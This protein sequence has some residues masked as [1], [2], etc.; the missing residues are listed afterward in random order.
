MPDTKILIVDDEEYILELVKFNLEK[1]GFKV[2]TAYDGETAIKLVEER[3]P[4]LIIL[5]IMLPVM[6]GLEVCRTLK[7]NNEFSSIP[8]IMLTARG[9]EFDMV[10][11]LEIGADDYIRK[12]FSPREL[13]ARVKARLRALKILELKQAS[14]DKVFVYKDI[15]IIPDK[16]EVFKGETKLDLTPKE[17]DLLK[18]LSTNQGKVYTREILLEK[19]WGYEFSGDTRTVDVH[20]RHLRQKLRD[21]SNKPIYIETV[22]GV[23]YRFADNC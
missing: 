1:E 20:I 19:V 16:Y 2:I 3:F 10:L 15:I 11:G 7:S 12:P 18:L 21:D 14:G 17:F 13:V 5:D 8:I 9:E 22:R 4:N 23:G 6:D